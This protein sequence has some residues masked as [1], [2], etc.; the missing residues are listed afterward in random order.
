ML[1]SQL[2]LPQK[3]STTNEVE[4]LVLHPERAQ[5]LLPSLLDEAA[6]T[7]AISLG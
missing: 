1:G 6:A 4:E 2:K 3:F 5:T 7:P